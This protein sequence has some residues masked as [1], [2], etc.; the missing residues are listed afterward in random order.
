MGIPWKE[1]MEIRHW[2]YVASIAPSDMVVYQG[3]AFPEWKG[4]FLIGA[5][6]R[7]QAACGSDLG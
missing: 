5:N 2:V 7:F 3:D 1:G 4:S 6:D